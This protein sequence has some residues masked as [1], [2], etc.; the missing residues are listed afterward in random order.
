MASRTTRSGRSC[1]LGGKAGSLVGVPSTFLVK[2]LLSSAKFY[3][4]VENLFPRNRP[5]EEK[6]RVGLAKYKQ[7]ELT[8]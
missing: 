8:E 7:T 1:R 4:F 6:I 5:K 2:W 3:S